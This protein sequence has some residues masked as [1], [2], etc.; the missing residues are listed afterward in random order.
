MTLN[1]PRSRSQDFLIKYVEYEDRCNVGLK[2]FQIGNDQW[3]FV[4]PIYTATLIIYDPELAYF[5]AIKISRQIWR[6][7]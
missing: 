1:R 6:Q 2:R 4:R 5:N 7:L 3:A